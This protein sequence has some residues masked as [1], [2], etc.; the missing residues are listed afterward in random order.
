MDS[1]IAG[2]PAFSTFSIEAD[3]ACGH[4]GPAPCTRSSTTRTGKNSEPETE[5]CHD[6]CI[7]DG[8]TDSKGPLFCRWESCP[9]HNSQQSRQVQGKP[10]Y[11]RR[12]PPKQPSRSTRDAPLRVPRRS[13]SGD[14]V[15]TGE[16]DAPTMPRLELWSRSTRDGCP[17]RDSPRTGK[18]SVV[19]GQRRRRRTRSPPI[20]AKQYQV[21]SQSA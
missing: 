13:G 8:R 19:V 17:S 5:Q 11:Q 18:R 9:P 16:D 12:L 4:E 2:F 6:F 7:Q 1:L 20:P 10:N 14:F 15:A 21:F 3:N